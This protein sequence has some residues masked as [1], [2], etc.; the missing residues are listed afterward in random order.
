MNILKA[1]PIESLLKSKKIR[2]KICN[3]VVAILKKNMG[4]ATVVKLYQ[5][6]SGNLVILA[7]KD[8]NFWKIEPKDFLNVGLPLDVSAFFSK[9]IG[10]ARGANLQD[11]Y[12]LLYDNGLDAGIDMAIYENDA[13]V[14]EG[15]LWES[16]N[17]FIAENAE[18]IANQ[19]FSENA[20]ESANELADAIN[21]EDTKELT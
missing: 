10:S 4:G 9:A 19:E 21:T 15:D 12:I 17:N 11:G 7:T 16:A 20:A 6:G 2:E 18:N 8:G 5:H 1:L 13:I 14:F 3:T